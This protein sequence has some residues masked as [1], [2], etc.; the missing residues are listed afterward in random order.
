MEE[1]ISANRQ[2]K[3]EQYLAKKASLDKEKSEVG[4]TLHQIIPNIISTGLKMQRPKK[5]FEAKERELLTE[6][7]EAK[8]MVSYSCEID[9][10]TMFT[11]LPPGS[12]D[13]HRDDDDVAVED[14]HIK[15]F[16]AE[17]YTQVVKESLQAD[18]E[19]FHL[20]AEWKNYW[21]EICL[22]HG[23][24]NV[25]RRDEIITNKILRTI[26]QRKAY[27]DFIKKDMVMHP[28]VK[29]SFF[30]CKVLYPL[31][32][33]KNPEREIAKLSGNNNGT[34]PI[35]ISID[36]LKANFQALKKYGVFPGTEELTWEEFVRQ[37]STLIQP[38]N[39][40]RMRIFGKLD[41]EGRNGKAISHLVVE[42]WEM[43]ASSFEHKLIGIEG[44]EILLKSCK[45]DVEKDIALLNDMKLPSHLKISAFDTTP[46][47]VNGEIAYMKQYI[48]PRGKLFEIKGCTPESRHLATVKAR[49]LININKL[50][51]AESLVLQ[52]RA[53]KAA[54]D[55]DQVSKNKLELNGLYGLVS[56]PPTPYQ[57]LHTQMIR[58]M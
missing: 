7:A 45:E 23:S 14:H 43:I 8:G 5:L 18:L 31:A 11:I 16:N 56:I 40:Q 2:E 28:F 41:K 25:N 4:S 36:L 52:L 6:M 35:Y 30:L 21:D 24:A 29:P 1:K 49:E 46:F 19:K 9:N 38:K 48:F 44:D 27:Q 37:F 32:D 22:Y 51:Y 58:D 15:N 55:F 57:V 3:Y 42:I 39:A 26:R 17:F 13:R 20:E 34:S 50:K 12:K 33:C 54:N 10:E 53:A 47:A